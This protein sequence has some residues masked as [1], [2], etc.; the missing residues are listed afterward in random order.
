MSGRHSN[1]Y[2]QY[3]SRTRDHSTFNSQKHAIP[4][5]RRYLAN[6]SYLAIPPTRNELYKNAPPRLTT[7]EVARRVN[8]PGNLPFSR[9]LGS[10]RPPAAK[11]R[12]VRYYNGGGCATNY[13]RPCT[14]TS[15]QRMAKIGKTEIFSDFPPKRRYFSS[16]FRQ[17]SGIDRY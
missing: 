9:R 6:S 15:G 4:T 13:T 10:S 7:Q 14:R 3:F 16:R 11:P 8:K 5:I 12:Q 17:Y 2:L 1:R